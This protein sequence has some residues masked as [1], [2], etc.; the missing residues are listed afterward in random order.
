MKKYF[1]VIAI[2]LLPCVAAAV[3]VQ[4]MHQGVI[5]RKS[6]GNTC[7]SYYNSA[8]VVL[9]WNGNHESGTNYGCDSSG[10]ALQFTATAGAEIDDYLD[11]DSSN[12][13]RIDA[14]EENIYLDTTAN[15]YMDVDSAQTVCIRIQQ[16]ATI[17]TNMTLFRGEKN[18]S[19]AARLR[20]LTNDTVLGV[21][22]AGT[23]QTVG[24][25][26]VT[27]DTWWT[28]AYSWDPFDDPTV[29]THAT[30]VTSTGSSWETGSQEL[31]AACDYDV[32]T[33]IIGNADEAAPGQNVYIS[34]F[35]VLSGYQTTCPF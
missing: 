5:A 16:A 12:E 23:V 26:T 27:D 34:D 22:D 10:A 20:L 32:E 35:A 18:G 30:D 15:Q 11:S 4:Q 9:S 21:Y 25:G 7:P 17:S 14:D 29:G 31:A 33:I 8:N 28:V 6:A 1:T 24:I 19:L 3:S 2:L 13:M